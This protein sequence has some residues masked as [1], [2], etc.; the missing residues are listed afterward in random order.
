MSPFLFLNLFE[1]SQMI[2]G[3]TITDT[4]LRFAKIILAAHLILFKLQQF[5]CLAN[6]SKACDTF[7]KRKKILGLQ[8]L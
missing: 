6:D 7:F 8:P 1:A 5:K 3:E 2:W 4:V